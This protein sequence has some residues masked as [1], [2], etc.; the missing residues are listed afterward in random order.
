[1]GM[2]VCQTKGILRFSI[3]MVK[4]FQ[5]ETHTSSAVIASQTLQHYLPDSQSLN[6]WYYAKRLVAGHHHPEHRQHMLSFEIK[7]YQVSHL[8]PTLQICPHWALGPIEL[9]LFGLFCDAVSTTHYRE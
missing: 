3:W 8:L 1:M 2:M 9:I 6:L 4:K 5:T 7:R